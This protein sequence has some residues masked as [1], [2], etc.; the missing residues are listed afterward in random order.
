[1]SIAKVIA[2]AW[3]DPDFKAKLLSDPEAA[4]TENG[5]TTPENKTLKVIEDSDD[6]VHFVLPKAPSELGQISMDELE[7]L[8]GGTPATG[9]CA[10]SEASCPC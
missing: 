4:L 9:T 3:S 8:A 6:T 5:Y 1:M 2:H 7:K 10:T